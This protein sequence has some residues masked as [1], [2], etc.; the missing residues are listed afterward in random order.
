MPIFTRVQSADITFS[1]ILNALSTRLAEIPDYISWELTEQSA[2]NKEKILQYKNMSLGKRCFIIANG[3]SLSKTNLELLK[4]EYT[5]G[6]NRIYL[7]F[8][9]STFRPTFYVA[10]NEL[11]IQQFYR[12][13]QN[14]KILSMPKFLNWNCRRFFPKYR[15]DIVFLKTKH[16]LNDRIITDLT[17]S[18]VFGATV[19]FV[20]LQ[21]AFFMGFSKVIIIGLDH[22]YSEQGIPNSKETRSFAQDNS[23]F[24]PDYFPK[25]S[26]W[27]LP[28]LLR[29]E[30]DYSIAKKLY[31][32][33]GR[34]IIDATI[35]G[36]CFV[37]EKTNFQDLFTDKIDL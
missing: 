25:G 32:N 15:E 21:L 3:P 17:K 11:V 6:L 19:T 8:T 16:V 26:K 36:N 9:N 23:H 33:S 13:I 1:R 20:T 14:P 29:S 28:D 2:K 37:F 35:G 24:H 4:N 27:Q 5:F 34:K 22:K 10:S 7:N 12:D 31:E 30:I 18:I